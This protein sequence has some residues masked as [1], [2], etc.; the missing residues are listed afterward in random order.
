VDTATVP[1]NSGL[2]VASGWCGHSAVYSA[3][4]AVGVVVG[5]RVGGVLDVHKE[6]VS[7]LSIPANKCRQIN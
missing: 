3:A 6:G 1:G 5:A 7:G 2:Y 4:E